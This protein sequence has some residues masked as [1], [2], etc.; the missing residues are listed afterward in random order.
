ME[1]RP[2]QRLP[3]MRDLS[4]AETRGLRLAQDAL[5]G[6]LTLHNYRFLDT[7]ALEPTELFLRK[8]GGEL[9]SWM[10]TFTEPGG[11]RVSLRPEF[12]SPVIRLFVQEA[13]AIPLPVRWQYAGPVYRYTGGPALNRAGGPAAS[14]G[15]AECAGARQFT[16]VGAELIGASGHAADAEVM[17]LACGCLKALGLERLRLTVG[18]VGA[19]DGLLRQ[20]QLSERASLFLLRSVGDLAGSAGGLE[21][22]REQAARMGLFTAQDSG[23][24][25][26]WIA[27]SIASQN[28]DHGLQPTALPDIDAP[29]GVRTPEEIAER[30]RR[31]REETDSPERLERA[32]GFAAEVAGLRG[33]PEPTLEAARALVARHGLDPEPLRALEDG[34]SALALHDLQGVEVAVDLGLV[35]DIAYYTGMVFEIGDGSAA[36]GPTL[37]GGG[38]YDGLVKALGGEQDT[39][40]LGFACTL[41][42]AL[43][44]LQA[45]DPSRPLPGE[46]KRVLVISR[47]E[48]AYGSALRVA[49]ALRLD[50]EVAEVVL[51]EG[52]SEDRLGYAR[53]RGVEAI[54]MVEDD[55]STER[56]Q[57]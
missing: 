5:Q 53:T 11:H 46:P 8:S 31:K 29:T 19:V 30:L 56:I 33:D 32:L 28:A 14:D 2:T 47:G 41:E 40:A 50:G 38:R 26:E 54:V 48:N 9:A 45:R 36:E 44:A 21:R 25:R 17:A 15:E 16:Q 39:P 22:V 20:F 27:S 10:Y 43:A 13:P 7:P 23:G 57:V 49:A 6:V 1:P 37:A 24:E 12:T 52:I 34:L 4:E 51:S 35:R 55:G 18:S 42:S 3:G